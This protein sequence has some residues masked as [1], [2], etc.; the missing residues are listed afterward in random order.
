M[1][2][3]GVSITAPLGLVAGRLQAYH[4]GSSR[5]IG[6]PTYRYLRL[7]TYRRSQRIAF[8]LGAVCHYP[9]CS[10]VACPSGLLHFYLS[11]ANQLRI[12]LQ[13]AQDFQRVG[14]R[15]HALIIFFDDAS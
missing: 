11:T 9:F 8:C 12:A 1:L 14:W 3:R 7:A 4:E 10:V 13:T 6:R 15:L 5:S 2:S